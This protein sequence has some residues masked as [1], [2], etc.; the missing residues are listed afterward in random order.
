MINIF[1]TYAVNLYGT[2]NERTVIGFDTR[3]II[4]ARNYVSDTYLSEQAIWVCCT[5]CLWVRVF[6]LLRYNEYMGRFVGIVE[7]LFYDIFIFFCFYLL[8]LIFFALVA[9]LSFRTLVEYNTALAAFKNLF[10]AS[11][12]TF[13]FDNIQEGELGQYYGITFMILFLIVNIGL[14]MSLFISIITVLFD[15]LSPNQHIFFMLETLKI[16]PTTQ[17][18]KEYSALVSLPTPINALHFV[19]APFLL[20]SKHPEIMNE[21]ILMAVYIPTILLVSIV[22]FIGYNILLW[23]IT[24][25]KLFFHKLVMIFVYSKS[26]RVS[27]ADKFMNW[28]V[29]T[30]LGPFILI[31]NTVVDVYYFVRHMLMRD[32]FKMKHKLDGDR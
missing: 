2:W 28:V 23:P 4:Y 22:L 16:R 5:V 3:A 19:L 8:E 29:F 27:R 11:F 20:T 9:Q 12:G 21:V 1:V 30:L 32:L 17:A 31:T 18:D 25:V 26:F 15:A 6:Y 7:R 10:Y 14:I 13:S 24:Y